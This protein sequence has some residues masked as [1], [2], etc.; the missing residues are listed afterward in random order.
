MGTR[1]TEMQHKHLLFLVGFI[2]VVTLYVSFGVRRVTFPC[3]HREWKLYGLT[4]SGHA[5]PLVYSM[6][7]LYEIRVAQDVYHEMHGCYAPSFADLKEVG[8][9]E[10]WLRPRFEL[11]IECYF[12]KGDWFAVTRDNE[13][14]VKAIA[15]N[16]TKALSLAE[17]THGW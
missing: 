8:A 3:G 9:M 5:C 13:G 2:A 12:R 15:S 11:H 7:N 1:Y 14:V 4:M 10:E 6:S 17:T 16:G